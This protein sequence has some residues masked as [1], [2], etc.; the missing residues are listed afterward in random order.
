[1]ADDRDALTRMGDTYMETM[2]TARLFAFVLAHGF[3]PA[4]LTSSEVM[5]LARR[6]VE[7]G[8]PACRYWKQECV[9]EPAEEAREARQ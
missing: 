7:C 6:Y 5:K 4:G 9:S 1:M 3:P 8:A 2:A